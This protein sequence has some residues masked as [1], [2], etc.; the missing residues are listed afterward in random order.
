MLCMDGARRA[1]TGRCEGV[2]SRFDVDTATDGDA[3]RAAGSVGRHRW[4]TQSAYG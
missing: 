3:L 2:S 4:P 1:E